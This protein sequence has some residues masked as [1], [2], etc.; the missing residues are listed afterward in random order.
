MLITQAASEELHLA[1]SL[2]ILDDIKPGNNGNQYEYD[3]ANDA[4]FEG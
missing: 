4:A 3:E 2:G 1:E